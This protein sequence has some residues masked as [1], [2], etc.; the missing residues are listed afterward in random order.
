MAMDVL[1]LIILAISLFSVGLNA[2]ARA[3]HN[4]EEFV[5]LNDV[6][7]TIY[8]Q[9]VEALAGQEIGESAIKKA[10]AFTDIQKYYTWT[11][12]ENLHIL[13]EGKVAP[14]FLIYLSPS[15]ETK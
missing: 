13:A 5:T 7:S 3:A 11:T 12:P 14:S 9:L 6:D 4:Q 8:Q 10:A 1:R 2:R 15:D